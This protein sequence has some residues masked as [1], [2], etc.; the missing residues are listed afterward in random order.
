MPILLKA[1]QHLRHFLEETLVVSAVLK[2]DHTGL[3]TRDPCPSSGSPALTHLL[4]W[5]GSWETSSYTKS[6]LGLKSKG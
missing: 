2:A 4:L 6:F 3:S 5:A 1:T